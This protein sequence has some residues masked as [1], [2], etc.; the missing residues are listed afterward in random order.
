M[1]DPTLRYEVRAVAM[2]A[3]GPRTLQHIQDAMDQ[4]QGWMVM[5]RFLAR[6]LA[7]YVAKEKLMLNPDLNK[8]ADHI[9]HEAKGKLGGGPGG[10]KPT[11]LGADGQPAVT[12][13]RA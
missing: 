10:Q 2:E 4:A 11:I 7:G 8:L 6:Q 9:L 5:A 13:G 12:G 1:E 3:V